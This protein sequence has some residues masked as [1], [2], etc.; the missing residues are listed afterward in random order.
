MMARLK[1]IRQGIVA[2]EALSI[3][4]LAA[5]A[6]T[7]TPSSSPAG[8]GTPGQVSLVSPGK[9]MV[10]THLSYKPFQFKDSSGNV[11]GFDVDM[12]DLVAKKLGVTQEIVDIDFAS[13]TS[14][15]VFA[16]RKCDAAAGAVTITDKRKEAVAFSDP[17]FSATQA[18]LVKTD[19]GITDCLSSAARSWESR[20]IPPARSTPRRTR[21]PT[22]TTSWSMTTCRPP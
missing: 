6:P 2:V 16:A 20:P 17:Y 19:S 14:G 7:Q 5:C 15:A 10:C 13:M 3:I 11:V 8:G 21:K 9:L 4:L 12:L 18:L 1:R 22:A